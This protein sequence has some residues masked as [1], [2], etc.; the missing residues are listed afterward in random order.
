MGEDVDSFIENFYLA[1]IINKWDETK[2]K[3]VITYILVRSNIK[4]L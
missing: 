2:I 1:A 4:I 3:Y